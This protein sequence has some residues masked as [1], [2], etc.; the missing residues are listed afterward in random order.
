MTAKRSAAQK[1]VS[2]L[3]NLMS[4]LIDESCLA[5]IKKKNS[6]VLTT[7]R[8]KGKGKSKEK[9]RF[10]CLH[11]GKMGYKKIDCFCKYSKK[12][13]SSWKSGKGGA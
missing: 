1:E 5:F 2:K 4:E 13:S 12:V 11:C 8:N 3:N 10:K 6:V 7:G 9:I